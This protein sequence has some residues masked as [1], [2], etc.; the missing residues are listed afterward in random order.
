L[1]YVPEKRKIP[2]MKTAS[3][4]QATLLAGLCLGAGPAQA[5]QTT[6]EMLPVILRFQARVN[7]QP[8]RCQQAYT[9][10][11]K[12][13]SVLRPKDFRLYL[14]QIALT[15]AAGQTVPLQLKQ[16]GQWQY[17]NVALLDFEDKTGTCTTGTPETHTEIQGYL[18]KGQYKGL[19]F[20]LGVPFELNH[21]DVLQAPPPLNMSSLFWI[22]Q[23]GYRF[24]RLDFN[25]DAMPRGFFIHLGSTGCQS[26]VS[27]TPSEPGQ[28]NPAKYQAPLSCAQPNRSQV[29]L[30]H[31]EPERQQVL[32]DLGRLLAES[33]LTQNQPES[34]AGCISDA[35]DLDC[36]PIFQRLGLPFA[37]RKAGSQ[38]F[39]FVE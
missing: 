4:W 25:T 31:F 35:E 18:P 37:G 13:K 14:S 32:V 23:S 28:I 8:F 1:K 30:P 15:N 9:E 19:K 21:Q 26:Q 22:W 12:R 17:Q 16:D 27:A 6:P 29:H 10:V 38:Q 7:G 24:A 33:D 3:L 34:T 2:K 36:L 20:E 39:F 5:L 11:G